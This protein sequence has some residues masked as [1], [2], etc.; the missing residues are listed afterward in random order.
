M[1]ATT[2]FFPCST[3]RN[4]PLFRVPRHLMHP[5]TRERN[6]FDTHLHH[7]LPELRHAASSST[8]YAAGNN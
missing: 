7:R 1:P 5:A 8:Q 2:P 4:D 3:A 6:L